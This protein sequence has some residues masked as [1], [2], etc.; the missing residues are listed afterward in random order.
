[1]EITKTD[2]QAINLKNKVA[3]FFTRS[4]KN[5]KNKGFCITK[6]I[7]AV[8]MDKWSLFIIYNLGYYGTLRFGELKSNISG[9]SSRMLSVTLK[10]LESHGIIE[11]KAYAEI[12]PRVEY[13]LTIFGKAFAEKSV[14]LNEWLLDR[15]LEK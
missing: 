11:R 4:I 13:K 10:K 1:M 5:R 9:V 8:V 2:N 15:Y 6:D 12:P 7:M 3:N 14:E